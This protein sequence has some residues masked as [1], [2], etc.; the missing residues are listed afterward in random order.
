[1]C[2]KCYLRGGKEETDESR[3]PTAKNGCKKKTRDQNTN[4]SNYKEEQ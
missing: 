1:M 2:G 3:T 4:N